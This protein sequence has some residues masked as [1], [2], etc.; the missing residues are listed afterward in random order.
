MTARRLKRMGLGPALLWLALAAPASAQPNS[1]QPSPLQLVPAPSNVVE[2]AVTIEDATLGTEIHVRNAAADTASGPLRLR[3]SALLVRRSDGRTV[4][5]TWTRTGEG[6]ASGVLQPGEDTTLL[7]SANLPEA[8]VYE[9]VIDTLGTPA[10]AAG[11]IRVVVTRT[12]ET[13]PSEFLADPK[14]VGQTWGDLGSIAALW[15]APRHA[16]TILGL[17]NTTTRRLDFLPPSVVAFARR[18][19]DAETAVAT[20]PMPTVDS[21][22]CASPLPAGAACALK[23]SFSATLLPGTYAIDVGVGGPSGGWS[24][25]T[26]IVRVRATPLLAFLAIV[27][28]AGAGWYISAWRSGGRRAL[29]GLIETT[30][31]RDRLQRLVAPAGDTDL[32]RLLARARERIDEVEV[33]LRRGADPASDLTAFAAHLGRLVDAIEISDGMAK[34]TQGG[35]DALRPRWK[36]LVAALGDAGAA[37]SSLDGPLRSLAADV[38]AWPGLANHA[39][40]ARALATAGEALDSAGGPDLPKDAPDYAAL[41]KAASD[42]L[43]VLDPDK[44]TDTVVTRDSALAALLASAR[45][46]A[47]GFAGKAASKLADLATSLSKPPA[48]HGARAKELARAARDLAV[49]PPGDDPVEPRL[50]ELTALWNTYGDILSHPAGQKGA[51]AAFTQETDATA[52]PP[53]SVVP[54]LDAPVSVFLP[55]EGRSLAALEHGRNRNELVTNLFVLVVI[56]GSGVVTLWAPDPTWGSLPNVIGAMLAG[57]AT[58]VAVGEAVVRR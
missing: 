29:D 38:S 5:A 14:P 30:R 2:T 32:A 58:H 3:L 33:G 42:S 24:Q 22:A 52:A 48:D 1:L 39:A 8:G 35:Q 13:L 7:L 20:G 36:A 26:L 12:A 45:V 55:G 10:A 6:S 15:T 47:G 37:G 9:T 50:K 44:P 43:V 27:I 19:A 49:N 54:A 18:S 28:G 4:R 57:L 40:A 56:G 53:Q 25:R 34:L 46:Q 21:A 16:E 23:L 41:R 51:V 11:R 17:R 31:L